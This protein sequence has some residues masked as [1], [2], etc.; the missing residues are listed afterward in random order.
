MNDKDGRSKDSDSKVASSATSWTKDAPLSLCC[1][2]Y[3]GQASALQRTGSLYSTHSDFTRTTRSR[4]GSVYLSVP[5]ERNGNNARLQ[6]LQRTATVASPGYVPQGGLG[7]G[8]GRAGKDRPSPN[9]LAL[10]PGHQPMGPLGANGNG[11]DGHD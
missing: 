11:F 4:V 6:G 10:P 2:C 3:K 9:R 1:R 5:K 8:T 7:H